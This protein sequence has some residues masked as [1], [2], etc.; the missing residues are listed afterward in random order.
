M[1]RRPTQTQRERNKAYMRSR[2]MRLKLA[3]RCVRCAASLPDGDDADSVYC[4]ECHEALRA[5]N[6]TPSGR[7]SNARRM[8]TLRARHRAEGLCVDCN[9]APEPGR[10][11][12]AVHLEATRWAQ[13]KYRASKRAA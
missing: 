13:R 11:R 6:K 8:R 4:P 3:G 10:T 1:R 7:L 9:S 2:Y 5:W 12:C